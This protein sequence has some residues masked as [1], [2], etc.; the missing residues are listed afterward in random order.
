MRQLTA[1]I[2]AL[3]V[4]ALV[5]LARA[6]DGPS[7]VVDEPV[8]DLGI[9]ESGA[10][11]TH[12]FRLRNEGDS[13]LEIREVD[14]DC[15]CT[16]VEYDRWIA[17]GQTGKVTAAVDV[18]TFVGPIAKY[19]VVLTNDSSNPEMSLAVKVEVRPLVQV[20]PGYVRFL[21][22]TG[23]QAQQADQ[24]IWAS[25]VDDFELLKVRSPYAFVEA[26]IREA[27]EGERRSEGQGRQWV[28]EVQLASNAP[29]GPMADHIVVE[30][31]H[32]EKQTVRIP[33]SG[34]VRPVLAVSPPFVDFGQREVTTAVRASVQIK[35]FS[36]DEI[37]LTGVSSDLPEIEAQIQ[38]DGS[39]HYVIVMLQPGLPKGEF[40]G[41]LTVTTDSQRVPTLEI[42]VKGIVL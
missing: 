12:T 32:P 29:I 28:V 11:V 23:D 17:P 22:V 37:S 41:K 27:E 13:P 38:L 30:T 3:L 36:E 9:V 18:S 25:D 14:P 26:R 33:V 7:L 20:Y 24:T 21:A 31:N 1:A 8:K 5:P 10:T 4:V 16:V 2:S 35:N 42:E 39:D 19:L 6:G 40:S 15:G 34:F